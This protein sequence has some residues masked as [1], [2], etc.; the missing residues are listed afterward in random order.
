M[1]NAKKKVL[2]VLAGLAFACA[3]MFS[4]GL[5]DVDAF[6]SEQSAAIDN[7]SMLLATDL[8]GGGAGGG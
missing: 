4:T 7:A 3:V 6:G 8:E 2:A 1:S 5:A